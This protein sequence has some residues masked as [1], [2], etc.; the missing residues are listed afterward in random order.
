VSGKRTI[1]LQGRVE[2]ITRKH[3][4]GHYLAACEKQLETSELTFIGYPLAL[5]MSSKGISK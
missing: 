5:T 2:G 4:T 1:T 3:S